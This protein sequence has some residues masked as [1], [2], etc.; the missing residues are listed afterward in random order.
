MYLFRQR[1]LGTFKS[2]SQRFGME[3]N[4]PNPTRFSNLCVRGSYLF[5]LTWTDQAVLPI[6]TI[7]RNMS[8]PYYTAFHF[9]PLKNWMNDVGAFSTHFEAMHYSNNIRIFR[10]T[11]IVRLV[12]SAHFCARSFDATTLI[13]NVIGCCALSLGDCGARGGNFLQPNGPF[14]DEATGLYHLF[15]QYN[16]HGP[17]WGDMNW[18][19]AVSKDMFHWVGNDS[20]APNAIQ[21]LFK[22]L[23]LV[24][25]STTWFAPYGWWRESFIPCRMR[26]LGASEFLCWHLAFQ[27]TVLTS[28]AREILFLAR[29]MYQSRGD[30]QQK[31]SL[32]FH[33]NTRHARWVGPNN[34]CT[35]EAETPVAPPVLH[36]Q[37]HLP[38]ALT[39][40]HTCVHLTSINLP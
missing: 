4:A 20:L 7:R 33:S 15:A 40:D 21:I 34:R 24:P 12:P 9:Q 35:Y 25:Q 17:K 26:A 3:T 30:F 5:P 36:V 37:A 22:R 32:D 2:T 14:Y 18:Y 19:H 11:E 13:S 8:D 28:C 27:D 23:R 39:P 16:P 31:M 6:V 10:S 29:S 38:V 1:Q